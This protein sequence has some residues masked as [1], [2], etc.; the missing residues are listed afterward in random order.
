[1]NN[2]IFGL[3]FQLKIDDKGDKIRE[4]RWGGRFIPKVIA[5]DNFKKMNLILI[6]FLLYYLD[7][8]KFHRS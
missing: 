5:P 2:Y 6:L 8:S 7:F 4:K 1:L 3:N